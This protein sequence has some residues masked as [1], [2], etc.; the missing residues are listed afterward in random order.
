MKRALAVFLITLFAAG[1]ASSTPP[2]TPILTPPDTRTLPAPPLA[3]G[4]ANAPPRGGSEA[5]GASYEF[6]GT[7]TVNVGYF[8]YCSGGSRSQT[9]SQT[10]TSD[11]TLWIGPPL[12]DEN[13]LQEAN[14]FDLSAGSKVLNIDGA[15]T[16]H[17][18]VNFQLDPRRIA[19]LQY[20]HLNYDNR[21][22]AISGQLTNAHADEAANANLLFGKR[23]L[24]PCMPQMGSHDWVFPLDAGSTLTGTITTNYAHLEIRGTSRDSLR[25]I[26]AT[27]SANRR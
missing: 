16:F 23:L 4:D 5:G 12:H 15:V 24:V 2:L 11:A 14:P 9:G 18:A 13:G 7:F 3:L 10:F 26:S 20:W 27:L 6:T 17:S 22:G 21:S 19:M 25:S 8:D 1:C